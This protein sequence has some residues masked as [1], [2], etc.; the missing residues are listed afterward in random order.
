[1]N[2]V[3]TAVRVKHLPSGIMIRCQAERT[4]LANKVILAP[5][6]EGGATGSE[7]EHL[8]FHFAYFYIGYMSRNLHTFFIPLGEAVPKFLDMHLM[9][10]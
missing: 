8:P 10:K 4:Q 6:P 1:M 2:K 7:F 5:C 9:W 3:E